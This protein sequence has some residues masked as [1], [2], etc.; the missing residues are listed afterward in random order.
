MAA[1]LGV[2]AV[3]FAPYCF[4][5]LLN[6]LITV[7]FTAVGFRVLRSNEQRNDNKGEASNVG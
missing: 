6:P 4:F 1:A 7:V 5:N 2:S 3:S